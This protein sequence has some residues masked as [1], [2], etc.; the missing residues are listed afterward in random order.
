MDAIRIYYRLTKPGIVYGNLMTAAAGFIVAADRHIDPGLFVAALGGTAL[1]IASACVVNNYI[2]RHIDRVMQRTKKRALATGSI[3]GS[4]AFLY[5]GI[6]GVTGFAVL[7]LWVNWLTVLVGAIGFIDYVVLYG[8][9]KRRT[10]HGTLIGSI[11]GSAPVVAGY[12]AAVD[13]FDTGALILFLILT[14]W[15]MPHFYAIALR[16]L[17]DYQSAHLPVLPA[18]HG[19]EATKRQTMMYMILFLAAV[20]ALW[21][22]GYAGTAYVVIMGLL[23]VGW[24][25]RGFQG[26]RATDTSL[27]ATK[28]FLYSLTLLPAFLLAVIV[29]VWVF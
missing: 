6:L 5:A 10:W 1:V 17:K 9:S 25:V 23:A 16:R 21:A 24:I 3:S 12:T 13:R 15:Q 29:D 28:V 2:D 19:A 11:S 7:A 14:F 20:I 8:W 27:W 18:V 26:F 22:F 4:A